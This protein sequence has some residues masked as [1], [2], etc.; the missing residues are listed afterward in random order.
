MS[1]IWTTTVEEDD[2]GNMILP[3]D[4]DMLSQLGWLEGDMLDFK[5]GSDNSCTVHNLSWEDRQKTGL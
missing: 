3:F 1:N 2:D 4:Q 5:M